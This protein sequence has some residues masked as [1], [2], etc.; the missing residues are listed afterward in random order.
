MTTEQIRDALIAQST[1][2]IA[3]VVKARDAFTRAYFEERGWN[4]EDPTFEQILEVRQQ[5]GWIT[6]KV[7]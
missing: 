4:M 2:D 3:V 6:P 5:P 7:I 1:P